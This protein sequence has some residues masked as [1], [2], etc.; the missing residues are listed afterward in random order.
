LQKKINEYFDKGIPLRKVIIGHGSNK[1]VCLI[2]V[3]TITGLALYLGFCDRHSFYD[4]EKRPEFSYT[5]KRARA[6]IEQHYEELLQTGTPTGSIFALKNF[7]WK[8]IYEHAGEVKVGPILVAIP[9]GECQV[10]Y[11]NRI[12]NLTNIPQG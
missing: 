6:A 8:D 7:G 10:D 5:I 3:P 11:E 9:P 12:R 2:P 1:D 4:Y